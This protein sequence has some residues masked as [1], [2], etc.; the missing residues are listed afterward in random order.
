MQPLPRGAQGELATGGGRGVGDHVI[1]WAGALPADLGF[2]PRQQAAKCMASTHLCSYL[3]DMKPW[4]RIQ[5]SRA[6][7]AILHCCMLQQG[8]LITVQRRLQGPQPLAGVHL[9]R[10]QGQGLPAGCLT[11]LQG[12]A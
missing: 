9:C 1:W 10:S 3:E 6:Q 7:P 4:R 5:H 12:R 8:V 2:V 11:T